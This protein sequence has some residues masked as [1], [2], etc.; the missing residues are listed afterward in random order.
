MPGNTTVDKSPRA[1]L[2]WVWKEVNV[3]ANQSATQVS[4]SG[5]PAGITRFALPRQTSIKTMTVQLSEALTAGWLD[6]EITKGGVATGK[7]IRMNSTDGTLKRV[8]FRPGELVGGPG[9]RIGVEW[10]S[11]ALMAP[12]GTIDGVVFFEV[13]D[14]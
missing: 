7:K 13:Q 4:V 14:S 8:D 12:S 9:D 1:F 10:G 6:F 11:G 5:F 2:P 3:V